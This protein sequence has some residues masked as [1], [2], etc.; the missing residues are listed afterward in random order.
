MMVLAADR[1]V[2]VC[3][4]QLLSQPNVIALPSSSAAAVSAS[5]STPLL[6]TS[7]NASSAVHG[8]LPIARLTSTVS[9]QK[10]TK[11]TAKLLPQNASAVPRHA[12]D[13]MASVTAGPEADVG[14]GDDEGLSESAGGV[15]RSSHNIVEKRYR[16]S[17]NDKLSELRE[18]VDGKD[19]KVLTAVCLSV[20]LTVCLSVCPIC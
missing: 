5:V 6:P 19:S 1:C 7:S 14:L 18:L 15:V 4:M 16:M 9:S 2:C 3:V 20:C 10:P 11:T 17:I 12:A 8:K 13:T